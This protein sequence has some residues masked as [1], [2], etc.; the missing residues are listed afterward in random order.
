MLLI[1]QAVD[2]PI[3]LLFKE[4]YAKN[5]RKVIT[6]KMEY[7][8]HAIVLLGIKEVI[9]MIVILINLFKQVNA[10]LQLLLLIHAKH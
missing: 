3:V 1:I 2:G 7:V 5:V 10:N 6:L 4:F 8:I 9:F